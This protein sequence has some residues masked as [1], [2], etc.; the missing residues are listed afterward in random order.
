MTAKE[1]REKCYDIR[2]LINQLVDD[3]GA[4]YNTSPAILE[5]VINDALNGD[6]LTV[7][8]KKKNNTRKIATIKDYHTIDYWHN[9]EM[10]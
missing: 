4:T 7:S 9:N 3:L 8:P 6:L 1:Y 10:I 2:V 5:K